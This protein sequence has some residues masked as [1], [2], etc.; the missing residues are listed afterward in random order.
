VL[1][2]AFQVDVGLTVVAALGLIVAAAYALLLMQR[3]FQGGDSDA[4]QGSPLRDFGAREMLVMGLLMAA[5]VGLG[6]YPQPLLDLSGPVLDGLRAATAAG[7]GG[8]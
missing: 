2:G 7:G 6:V 4:G 3:S 5:L 8:Q 1:L